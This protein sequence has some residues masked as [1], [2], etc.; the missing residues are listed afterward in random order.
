[1]KM[2]RVLTVAAVTPFMFAMVQ[3]EKQA[4][5]KPV[6]ARA[7]TPGKQPAELRSQAGDSD[8]LMVQ[9]ERVWGTIKA[10]NWKGLDSM[11]SDDF[12]LVTPHGFENKA[13][14][15]EEVKKEGLS[16]YTLSGW[17]V[18]SLDADAAIVMYRVELEWATAEGGKTRNTNCYCSSV[19]RHQAGRW[20]AASHQ[21]TEEKASP[22]QK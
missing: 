9:E 6:P 14:T 3:P 20:L 17:R 1:M 10:R 12:V 16:K 11:L 22:D 13:Q 18:I 2:C 19:W 7:G 15:L 4:P 8:A 5:A 21:E